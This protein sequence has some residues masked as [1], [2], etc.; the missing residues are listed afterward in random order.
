VDGAVN[1][2]LNEVISCVFPFC[3]TADI[4]NIY[5]LKENRI[6]N[7]A[8]FVLTNTK[9]H[10]CVILLT[11]VVF[12][13]HKTEENALEQSEKRGEL[14][15]TCPMRHVLTLLQCALL[16]TTHVFVRRAMARLMHTPPSPVPTG[17]RL[18]QRACVNGGRSSERGWRS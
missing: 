11:V 9:C 3:L 18:S 4:V 2:D 16:N 7:R 10:G 1:G 12:S 13:R 5:R 17:C 8:C 15:S 6:L 14:L